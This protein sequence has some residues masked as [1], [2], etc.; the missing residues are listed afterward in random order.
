MI[1]GKIPRHIGIS[2]CGCQIRGFPCDSYTYR[3]RSRSMRRGLTTAVWRA[4]RS[5]VHTTKSTGHNRSRTV[6]ARSFLVARW[7]LETGTSVP[8]ST[9]WTRATGREP[10]AIANGS[11]TCRVDTALV[12]G[13]SSCVC[14]H[15]PLICPE[16]CS[17]AM[18]ASRRPEQ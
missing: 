15:A 17:R 10:F 14:H 2:I 13:S 18:L 6:R 3:G 1:C 12:S 16:H 4:A 11:Q 8:V 9:V 5:S 7:F